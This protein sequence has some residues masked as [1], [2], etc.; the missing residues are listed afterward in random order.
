MPL[1][2]HA[3]F[4]LLQPASFAAPAAVSAQATHF[5][6][7]AVPLHTPVVQALPAATVANPHL[8]TEQVSVV[9]S[10]PSLQS[11][12]EEQPAH[13]ASRPVPRQIGAAAEQPASCAVPAAVSRQRTH[14]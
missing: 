9:H 12:A 10:F 4:A 7:D 11:V 14:T 3:G 8:P 13:A 2:S 5:S 1:A 6:A